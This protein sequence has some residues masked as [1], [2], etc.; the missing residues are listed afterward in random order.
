[1]HGMESDKHLVLRPPD[2]RQALREELI[3]SGCR[4]DAAGMIARR[5][6]ERLVRGYLGG[7]LEP[8]PPASQ[9]LE[10]AA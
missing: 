5:V 1:M 7:G 8:A 10:E 6:V 4:Q 3:A 2:W 9:S